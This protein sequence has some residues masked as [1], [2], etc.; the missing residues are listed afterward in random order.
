LGNN[1]FQP[2]GPISGFS[3]YFFTQDNM[4]KANYCKLVDHVNA[5]SLGDWNTCCGVLVVRDNRW[6]SITG[7]D[8][9][10]SN[11][12][13]L[14]SF[15]IIAQGRICTEQNLIIVGLGAVDTIALQVRLRVHHTV[16]TVRQNI[17]LLL[18]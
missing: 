5:C 2:Q 6:L 3:E 11:E 15:E 14:A 17:R 12:I 4:A 10:A 16:L 8:E 18:E 9:F 13:E 7:R 1:D